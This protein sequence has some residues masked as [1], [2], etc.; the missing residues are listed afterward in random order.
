MPDR[1]KLAIVI[2][3]YKTPQLVIDCLV[4]LHGQVDPS[5]ARVILVDNLSPDNSVEILKK[6]LA[7]NDDQK[8]VQLIEAKANA[9]FSAGNNV[10]MC[11]ADAEYY[12]LLNSDTI[13]RPGAIA[14]LLETAD[15]NPGAGL[16]SPRLEWPDAGPQQSCFRYLTPV[17]E[18]IDAAK[19][20][21]V[22]ALFK[23]YV[24]AM[25]VSETM[26]NPQ[27]TSFACVLVRGDVVRQIGL[28]DEGFFMYF[29][30][31]E[32]CRRARAA[33][34]E[35]IHNP[36]AHVVHLRGGSSPV[37]QRVMERKRVPRYYYVS[38]TR[39]FYLSYGWLGLM[40]ANL[41]WSLGRSI[42]KIRE[43][44]GQREAAVPARQWLDIWT[45]W[46]HPT[47]A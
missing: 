39:Y 26:V 6:W 18:F 36:K 2:I 17:S 24:V 12:L 31:V 27:W 47:A 15:R 32:Y 42:S 14:I 30:D 35:I 20:G 19:T 4:S 23:D 46:R 9:G 5:T 43:L 25:P 29:E 41:F 28:M 34:W 38:R 16:V 1:L 7:A 3:N 21:P 40:L 13:V 45:N 11:A 44:V 22:T 33:G 37:K 10:G 8:V